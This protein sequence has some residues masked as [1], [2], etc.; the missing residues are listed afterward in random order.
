MVDISIFVLPHTTA[1]HPARAFPTPKV[2]A[3]RRAKQRGPSMSACAHRGFCRKVHCRGHS[4]LGWAWRHGHPFHL[5]TKLTKPTK[6]V[7]GGVLSVLS[8]LSRPRLF[9]LPLAAIASCQP[10]R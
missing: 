9:S 5:R 10:P 4:V 2:C 7:L 3:M 1:A 6:P 8:V